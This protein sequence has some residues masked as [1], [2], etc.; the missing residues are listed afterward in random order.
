[1]FIYQGID[2]VD[3]DKGYVTGN[4][5]PCCRI[6]NCAKG[7]LTKTEFECWAKRLVIRYGD[8]SFA[9][10]VEYQKVVRPDLYNATDIIPDEG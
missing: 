5:L 2:R 1:M 4:V 6:C 3:S 7:T 9:S 8:L 10:Y